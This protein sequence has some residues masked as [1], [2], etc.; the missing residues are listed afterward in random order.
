MAITQLVP[1]LIVKEGTKALRFYAEVPGAE[2]LSSQMDDAGQVQN[3]GMRMGAGLF[4]VTD[5]DGVQNFSPAI[6]GG[7]ESS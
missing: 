1:R 5:E 7:T 4:S 6:L 3:A 2:L